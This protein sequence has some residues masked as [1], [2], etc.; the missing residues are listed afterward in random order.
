MSYRVEQKIKGK[1]YVYEVKSF[2]DKSKQQ[3]RQKRTYLGRKDEKT[4][5]IVLTSK[6]SIVPKGSYKFGSFFLLKNLS[7][8]I[9]L[10]KVLKKVFPYDYKK[11]LS[12]VFYKVIQA[13]PYYLYTLWEEETYTFSNIGLDSQRISEM[14]LDIGKNEK[15]IEVFFSN[16]INEQDNKYSVMFDISSISSY[17]KNNELVE[18]GYNRDKENLGQTNL[19][20][21]SRRGKNSIQLP[22]A[23]RIY[24]GSISDVVTLKNIIKLIKYYKLNVNYFVMDRGFYS[25]ENIREMNNKELKFL[26]PLV[27][28]TRKAKQLVYDFDEEISKPICSFLYNENVYSHVRT[29]VEINGVICVAHIFLDKERR[30]REESLLIRKMSYLESIFSEKGFKDEIS[31]EEYIKET[32]KS[33]R[34]FFKVKKRNKRVT[35]LKS[36]NFGT[37]FLFGPRNASH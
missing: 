2:W 11:Y 29:K 32:M 15:Q 25:K 1:I 33:K 22:L 18:R 20:I 36:V 12:V 17:F 7:D 23:Y 16:W 19:G 10:T 14:L 37:R 8:Q 21:I 3:A 34:R 26:L 35:I 31:A 13:D 4:G 5:K 28:T 6:N 30:A 27:F 9:N 24:P